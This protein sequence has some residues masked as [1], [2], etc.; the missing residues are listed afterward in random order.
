MKTAQE[1]Y[2]RGVAKHKQGKYQAAEKDYDKAIELKPKLTKTDL[3]YAY[4]NRGLAKYKQGKYRAAEKDFDKA[5]E[6]KDKLT[7]ADLAYAYHNRG[8]AK[9][10]QGK[11]QAAEKDFDKVM[12][13]KHKLTKTDLANAYTNRGQ[14]KYKQGKYQAAEKDYDEAIKLDPKYA[15]AYNN[16]GLAK[17]MQDKYQAAIDDHNQVIDLDSKN[18]FEF[19]VFNRGVSMFF[20]RNKNGADKDF[21]SA[22]KIN[23]GLIKTL[24]RSKE[25]SLNYNYRESLVKNKDLLLSIGSALMNANLYSQLLIIA[26]ELGPHKDQKALEFLRKCAHIEAF[27]AAQTENSPIIEARFEYAFLRNIDDKCTIND[28]AEDLVC[29]AVQNPQ[30]FMR[31]LQE[32]LFNRP[33]I[34]RKDIFK[35]LDGKLGSVSDKK[36]LKKEHNE[37]IKKLLLPPTQPTHTMKKLSKTRQDDLKAVEQEMFKL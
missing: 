9:Y 35:V 25:G 8:L 3:A 13:L 36:L 21:Q 6:L 19:T 32:L 14:A 17:Y 26:R 12:E 20:C 37:T 23:K 11:Y 4:H 18:K 16:R 34:G 29:L 31:L 1:Y 5:I 24:W 15:L 10:K 27:N 28:I 30:E 2:D 7:K 22:F 33:G